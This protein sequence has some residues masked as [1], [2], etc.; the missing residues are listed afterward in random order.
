MVTLTLISWIQSNL[1]I[2]LINLHAA[3]L[4]PV[5]SLPTR[6]TCSSSSLID[7][8][9]CDISLLPVCS[10]VIKTDVSDHYAIEIN[11]K[12]RALSS[13]NPK[14]KRLFTAIAKLKFTNKLL[15]ADWSQLYSI[16]D[17]NKAFNFFLR[18]L[19]RIYNKC[20]PFVRITPKPKK[21]PWLTPGILKSIKHKNKLFLKSKIDGSQQCYKS[22]RNQL[23]K[24]IRL[25]K[26]NHHKQILLHLKNNSIKMWSHL[27]SLINSNTS[28]N[29]VPVDPNVLNDFFTSVFKQAPNYNPDQPHTIPNSEFIPRSFFLTPISS[30]EIICTL[31]SLSDSSS[32]GYHH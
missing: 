29:S 14:S 27:K 30:N 16:N 24:I 11:L 28:N 3:A 8:F 9:L 17:T 32:P 20:F 4:H 22:Y 1:S 21:N 23:T 18:K 13:T 15:A 31:A 25:A 26:L 5:I 12:S 10:S 19:K 7:N 2:S 6:V